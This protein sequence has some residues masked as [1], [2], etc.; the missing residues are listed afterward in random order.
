MTLRC[1]IRRL[2][3]EQL[4]ELLQKWLKMYSRVRWTESGF[5]G[6]TSF[7]SKD[8]CYVTKDGVATVY[9]TVV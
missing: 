7:G 1:R 9:A 3:A 4:E 8:Y 2:N 6:Y 5:I